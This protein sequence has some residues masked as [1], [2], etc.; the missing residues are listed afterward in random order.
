MLHQVV[1]LI[2][3]KRRFAITSHI[4]PDGDSLGSSLGLFWLLRALDKEVEV[5]M[6]DEVPHAYAKLPGAETVRVTPR[7][8][9]QYDAVFVIECSDITRPG[10]IDLE[11]HRVVNTDPYWTT[12]PFAD[13]NWIGSRA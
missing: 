4:R 12:A 8:D 3:S 2:E 13:I 9:R 5:I 11:K 6:R 10:L 1:G 7:V